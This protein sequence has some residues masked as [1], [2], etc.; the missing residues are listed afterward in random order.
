[1]FGQLIR[2]ELNLSVI[3]YRYEVFVQTVFLM[4]LEPVVVNEVFREA[5]VVDDVA[6]RT[7]T[8]ESTSGDIDVTQD[9]WD[10]Q[11]SACAVDAVSGVR[12]RLRSQGE[13]AGAFGVHTSGLNDKVGR[14]TGNGF[15]LFGCEVFAVISVLFNAVNPLVAEGLV[16]QTFFEEDAADTGAQGRVSALFGLEMDRCEFGNLCATCVNHN[17]VDTALLSGT[18]HVPPA[19]RLRPRT[20]GSHDHERFCLR[21]ASAAGV[22]AAENELFG[23]QGAFTAGDRRFGTVVISTEIACQTHCG[24]TGFFRVTAEDKEFFCAVLIANLLHIGGNRCQ[25]FLPRNTN[26]SGIGTS[27]RIGALHRIKQ[28]IGVVESLQSCQ[29]FIA[30]QLAAVLFPVSDRNNDI[31]LSL[32]MNTAHRHLVA[33]VADR[34]SVFKRL[35]CACCF[36]EEAASRTD[37]GE[38]RDRFEDGS[39]GNFQSLCLV[40]C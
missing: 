8:E 12:K 4:G 21:A 33:V 30:Q 27:F 10:V 36:C 34:V 25:R 7:D 20:V 28:A 22:F 35:L 24:R 3:P 15:G 40:H 17:D 14:N 31:A 13:A 29:G 9:C 39:T 19:V 23:K 16:V 38:G 2:V 26:E 6:F 11:Q 1:M 18:D 37:G 5:V 32:E